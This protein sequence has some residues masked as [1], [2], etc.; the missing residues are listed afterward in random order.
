VPYPIKQFVLGRDYAEKAEMPL[1]YS[2]GNK[3]SDKE[4]KVRTGKEGL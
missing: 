4:A 2:K 3:C 1:G